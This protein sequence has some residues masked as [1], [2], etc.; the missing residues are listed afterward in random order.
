MSGG[1]EVDD[2]EAFDVFGRHL[3]ELADNLRG[4]AEMI[5]GCVADP[6]LFGAVGQIFGLGATIHCG[7]ARDQFTS[8]AGSI[9]TFREKLDK[10]K[11]TYRQ[12]EED[13]AGSIA[14]HKA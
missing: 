7:K 5:G 4:T 8:Y 3:D 1:Y 12:Q 6:G 9:G 10:A 11:Q 2:P 14:E 13:V